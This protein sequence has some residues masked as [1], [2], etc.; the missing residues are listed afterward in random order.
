MVDDRGLVFAGQQGFPLHTVLGVFQRLLVG[1]FGHS[2]ALKAH[3]EPSVVHHDEHIF[4]AAVFFANY[5]ADGSVV[6]AKRHHAG[7]AGVNTEFVFE[8]NAAHIVALT[9]RTVFIDQEL[10]HDE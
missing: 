7:R 9:Q 5:V 3:T 8:G 4:K 6:V 10:G 1:T 2:Y